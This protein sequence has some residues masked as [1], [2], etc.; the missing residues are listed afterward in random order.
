M[1]VFLFL[2]LLRFRERRLTRA[3]LNK[4]NGINSECRQYGVLARHRR[5]QEKGMKQRR[6]RDGRKGENDENQKQRDG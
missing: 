3:K 2:N 1:R 4:H 5:S 6:E